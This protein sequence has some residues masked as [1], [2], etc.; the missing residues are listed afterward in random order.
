M[1]QD[2]AIKNQILESR[3]FWARIVSSER[4][5]LFTQYTKHTFYEIQYALSGRIG[6]AVGKDGFI[7]VGQ[8]EFLIIPPDVYHQVVEADAVGARFIAAFSLSGERED[9]LRAFDCLAPCR[10]NPLMAALAEEIGTIGGGALGS[11]R[12][13]SLLESF[14]LEAL[15]LMKQEIQPE[16]EA[17]LSASERVEK[18]LRYIQSR[19]G[20]V[21]VEKVA[22]HFHLSSRHLGRLMK[23]SLGTTVIEEIHRAKLRRIEEY[24]LTTKLTLSE[25]AELCGFCDVYSMNKFFRRYNLMNLSQY[26]KLKEKK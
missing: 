7:N 18:I 5:S 26:R 25:I 12:L 16:E 21:S 9:F 17:L 10:G 13:K 8:G 4:E 14:L 1:K 6:M 20:M 2:I 23:E 15:A 11:A 24:I 22:S 3:I 19:E